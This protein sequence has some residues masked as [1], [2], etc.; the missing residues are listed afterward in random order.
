MYGKK[1]LSA[2]L[3]AVLASG[4]CSMPAM[5]A[6]RKK[7]MEVKM[8]VTAQI[9]PGD[10]ISQQQ[11][12]VTVD[13]SRVG[14]GDSE[15]INDGF[16]WYEGDVPKM[17]VKLYADE[18]YYFATDEK[19]IIVTGGTYIK[20]KRED[21]SRTLTVT[22][23]LPKVGEYTQSITRAEWGNGNLASWAKTEGTG[24]YEIILYR[25]GKSI[26]D[27]L[28]TK[29]T[30][31]DFTNQM[32]NPGSYTYQVR[33]VNDRNPEQKG[34]WFESSSKYIDAATAEK[35][36]STGEAL[37][38]WKQNQNGWWYSYQDG[39]YP[40]NRW[41]SI[42]GKWYYFNDKG[43]MATGWIS[44]NGK[45]YYCNPLGGAMV[46]NTKTPDGFQVGADGARIS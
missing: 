21:L 26:S 41:E 12:E 34:Q 11:A 31:I 32:R 37:G 23:D 7:I 35:N 45:Q 39:G 20:Q 38:E 29:G 9:M 14:V 2:V 8:T 17:E 30:S 5:A 33:P 24:S 25:D 22:I 43:Y 13:N 4:L 44:T 46:V 28:T 19:G 6:S 1:L 16:Q 10:S 15:F 18:G 36:R 42:G 3:A 27:T 40:V